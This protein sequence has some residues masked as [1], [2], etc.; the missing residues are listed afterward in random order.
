RLSGARADRAP[1][2]PLERDCLESRGRTTDP[3]RPP[4]V[5]RRAEKVGAS[6]GRRAC[7]GPVEARRIA[8]SPASIAS[9]ASAG[10]AVGHDPGG[11]ERSRGIVERPGPLGRAGPSAAGKDPLVA[12]PG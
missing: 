11:F 6:G 5:A 4:P 7:T 10:S 8:A 2:E 12:L 1:G 9:G 3:R